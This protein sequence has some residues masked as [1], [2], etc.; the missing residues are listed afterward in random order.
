MV[1]NLP[2]LQETWVRSLCWEDSLEKVMAT[3]ANI[4][5]WRIPCTEEPDRTAIHGLQELDMNERLTLSLFMSTYHIYLAISNIQTIS[6]RKHSASIGISLF[7][8]WLKHH[9]LPKQV[10]K[11][12]L[13]LLL[14]FL[15]TATAKSLQ[16]CPTLCDPI[17]GSPPGSFVP[18]ILQARKLEWIAISFSNAWKWKG[19]VKSLSHARL[20][21]TPWTAAYQAPPSVGFSWQ[22]FK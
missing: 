9:S 16:L 10:E 13:L 4:L 19:K 20:L 1:K 22:E 6:E 15:S 12:S 7:S 3:H 21:V 11:M 2:V 17:D 8:M 14:L 18:G 5:A